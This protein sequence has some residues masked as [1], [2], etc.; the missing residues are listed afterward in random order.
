[1]TLVEPSWHEARKAAQGC[2]APLPIVRVSLF[3]GHGRLSASP[4]GCGRRHSTLPGSA[5]RHA[6]R[7]GVVPRAAVWNVEFRCVR[8]SLGD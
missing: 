6:C 5:D 3:D 2:V 4:A 7:S 8:K 1:M